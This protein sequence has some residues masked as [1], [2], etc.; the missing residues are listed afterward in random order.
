[1][2][3][4]GG[5]EGTRAKRKKRKGRIEI[6]RGVRSMRQGPFFYHEMMENYSERRGV[7]GVEHGKTVD[8]EGTR[9]GKRKV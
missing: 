2:G 4:I 8:D 1:M 5:V 3:D 6:G 9:M 7:G